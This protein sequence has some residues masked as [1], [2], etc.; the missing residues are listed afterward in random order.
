MHFSFLCSLCSYSFKEH[1]NGQGLFQRMLLFFITPP[2][3]WQKWVGKV[4]LYS[5]INY[6][7][8]KILIHTACPSLFL[9]TIMLPNQ[10]SIFYMDTDDVSHTDG[11]FW[12]FL[13]FLLI[14]CFMACPTMQSSIS[15][16][17]VFVA[18]KTIL[19][20]CF[21]ACPQKSSSN[22]KETFDWKSLEKIC[23]YELI[24]NKN[25]Q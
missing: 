5:T 20:F 21:F 23:V 3:F 8:I 10:E 14:V 15:C 13:D 9:Y 12:I 1:K 7:D 11:F 19:P 6:E 22:W 4:F 2:M 25:S 17:G 18:A 24:F 16:V